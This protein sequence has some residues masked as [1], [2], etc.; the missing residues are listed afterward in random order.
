MNFSISQ[1]VSHRI[2]Y[3]GFN[4]L[5]LRNGSQS[6][7]VF[8]LWN[9]ARNSYYST[10]PEKYVSKSYRKYE[11]N[12]LFLCPK[13]LNNNDDKIDNNNNINNNEMLFMA[14]RLWFKIDYKSIQA[15]FHIQRLDVIYGLFYKTIFHMMGQ[16]EFYSS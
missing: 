10:I 12:I 9:Y 1:Y 4:L 5:M 7:W 15:Q 8:T 13:F 11:E 2:I 16:K 14:D 3:I 6:W